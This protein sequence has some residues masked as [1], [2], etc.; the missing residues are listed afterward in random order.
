MIVVC[1]PICRTISHEK[2]NSGFLFALRLAYP[3]EKI[4]FYAESSHISAI[5]EMLVIDGVTI[6]NIEYISFVF[7]DA[8]S[9]FGIYKNF[10]IF[11]IL[12]NMII[13]RGVNKIM[14]L[15]FSSALLY[16]IKLLTLRKK[17]KNLNFLFVLHGEF[18]H[19][20][21]KLP[22]NYFDLLEIPSINLMANTKRDSLTILNFSKR[23]L[24][25]LIFV[26]RNLLNRLVGVVKSYPLHKL[27]FN[28][29]FNKKRSMLYRSGNRYRY[30]ALS[31]H[32]IANANKYV[33]TSRL[34]I[35]GITMPVIF[36][37][38]VPIVKNKKIKFA[39]FG[40]SNIKMLYNI[41]L[42]LSQKENLGEY[43]IRIVGMDNRNVDLMFANVTCP[44]RGKLLQR[45]EMESQISDIDLVLILYDKNQY[46]LGCSLSIMEMLSYRKPILHFDNDCINFFNDV[47]LPIGICCNTIEE[48][49]NSMVD[50]IQNFELYR[51]KLDGFRNNIDMVR[52]K[53]SIRKSSL[54]I[55]NAFTW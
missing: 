2:V 17:Y 33:D 38:S 13:E 32:I 54:E 7:A 4:V 42:R 11:S 10:H 30:L 44:G 29:L 31:P 23:L 14:F 24:K 12:F 28:K 37:N 47:S 3:D 45:S 25:K 46:K 18:E 41:S 27:L 51:A 35:Y 55:R 8:Y 15:T 36:K 22:G 20:Q 50:M 53:Y 40:Y 39:V 1:E 48:Y 21:G 43:E 6:E 26:F 5:K 9:F 52:I 49:V 16:V 19:I 34:N